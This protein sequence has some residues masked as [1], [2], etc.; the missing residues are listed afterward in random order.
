[1]SK[2]MEP[3]NSFLREISTWL[4]NKSPSTELAAK[5][6][7]TRDW[8][9]ELALVIEN[10]RASAGADK[11]IT[12]QP[13]AS[14]DPVGDDDE[15]VVILDSVK[16]RG[17][18]TDD[19]RTERNNQEGTLYFDVNGQATTLAWERELISQRPRRWAPYRVEPKTLLFAGKPRGALD[20]DAILTESDEPERAFFQRISDLLKAAATFAGFVPGTAG[21]AASAAFN[22]GAAVAQLI[23]AKLQDDAEM[24]YLGTVG[25]SRA[26]LKYGTYVLTRH[27][28]GGAEAEIEAQIRVKKFVKTGLPTNVMIFLD[29]LTFEANGGHAINNLRPEDRVLVDV[30]VTESPQDQEEEPRVVALKVDRPYFGEN[31][32][33]WPKTFGL[34]DKLL[35]D[36]KWG[37]NIAINLN[38]S[39]L[40]RDINEEEWM[41]VIQQTGALVGALADPAAQDS[42]RRGFQIAEA[43]RATIVKFL[44]KIRFAS[45]LS[46]ALFVG[47]AIDGLYAL[48][49]NTQWQDVRIPLELGTYGSA[50][51][52]LKVKLEFA[53]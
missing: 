52:S 51:F 32:A 21:S 31:G 45:S 40:P 43:A 53:P 28:Q 30:T 3:E 17:L 26:A 48:Q 16:I 15:V 4:E 41:E 11:V 18:Y 22:L 39:G 13:P 24:R 8:V 10:Y 27:S 14:G 1:M 46:S 9:D 49:Q 44:P 34:E 7:V 36:G 2:T 20:F 47:D 37:L 35:Y 6:G 12:L 23:K 25:G 42:V 50:I 5:L 38:M 19:E 29:S 33:D